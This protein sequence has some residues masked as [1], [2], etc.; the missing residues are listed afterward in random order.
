M[1]NHEEQ[2]A[3]V[4]QA[5]YSVENL[6]G[7]RLMTITPSQGVFISWVTD[8]LVYIIVLN[9]FDEFFNDHI[10]F[11][12][13]WISIL[14]A[15]LF[16]ILLVIVGKV[17]HRVHHSLKSGGHEIAA[18]VGAYLVLFFGKLAIIRIINSLFEEVH[19]HGLL[20][21]VAMILTMIIASI[22]IWKIFDA[23]GKDY[24][25][26]GTLMSSRAGD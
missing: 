21:E 10:H 14:A 16:K 25:D 4:A 8:I 22:V 5:G 13:F 1:A 9:L 19:M 2:P 6:L 7:A 3:G 20:Y 15:I 17:E 11:G 26:V 23:L 24:P 12:S 18:L